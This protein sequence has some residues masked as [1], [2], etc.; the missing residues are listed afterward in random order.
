MKNE[1]LLDAIGQIDDNLIHD[2]VHD[3]CKKKKPAWF[4]WGVIA[5]CL[6]LV[7]AGAVM[8]L[9]N[10]NGDRMI[11]S[12]YSVGMSS[13]YVEPAP[14]EIICTTEV[15]AAREKYKGENVAYLLKFDI[16]KADGD[17]TDE[18]RNTEYQRLISLG[19]ELYTVETWT[20]R[21]EGEKVYFNVVVGCF[22]EEQLKSFNNN[23]E[24]GYIFSFVT[25]GDGSPI[26]FDEKNLITDF[27]TNQS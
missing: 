10:E 21:G 17:V 14:G 26:S 9:P 27:E 23:T 11:I 19:Y 15:S 3:T 25:N 24:Y 16:S 5:A 8:M 4:K 13:C 1:K 7:I 2:A 6:C 22:T 20:Y 12:H 18:E